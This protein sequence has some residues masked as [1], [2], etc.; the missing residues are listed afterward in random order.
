MKVIL[1]DLDGTLIDSTEAIL[2]GFRVTF[3]K[4]NKPYPGDR[5]I[6]KLI[7]LPLEIMFFKLGID[8]NVD[9]YVNTYKM[10]YRKISTQKTK[11][12]PTSKEAVIE[13][14]KF[15]R[16]GIVTTKTARYSKELLEHFGLMDYFE[17]LIGREDVENPK[18]HPEPVLKAIY[19]MKANKQ[20]AF[21]VGDTC[22]D[23][24][25][26]KEAGVRAIGVR[27]EYDENLKKC[28]EIIK[29]NVLEA[30]EFIKNF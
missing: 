21:M 17:V 23:V 14:K 28:T 29:E 12:L 2:E 9:Q 8:E 4:F 3:E 22:L 15:A 19:L 7:G 24:L 13:A 1:F 27:W 11:L 20:N 25:S 26:A 6:K 16:L 18:P 30:V 5:E 10:H